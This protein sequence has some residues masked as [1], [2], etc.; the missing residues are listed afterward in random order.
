MD[1]DNER[2]SPEAAATRNQQQQQQQ[3]AKLERVHQDTGRYW[4]NSARPMN[5]WNSEV[6]NTRNVAAFARIPQR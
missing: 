1:E 2:A 4:L 3:Q 6:V 5:E